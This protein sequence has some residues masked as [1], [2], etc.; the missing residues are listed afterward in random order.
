MEQELLDEAKEEIQRFQ[1]V[2]GIEISLEEMIRQLEIRKSY[3]STY[4]RD[5]EMEE[6]FLF[7]ESEQKDAADPDADEIYDMLDE[8]E[9]YIK[10]YDI[11]ES[12][13]D[14]MSIA[15]EWSAIRKEYGTV[16]L[17]IEED[18]TS[19]ENRKK[20]DLSEMGMINEKQ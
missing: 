6:I 12:S 2:Y 11:D 4:G 13:Y 18:E 16:Y 5:Y 8:I 3:I 7:Q 1:D 14:G 20:D 17:G 9:W 10:K 15:E 19:E